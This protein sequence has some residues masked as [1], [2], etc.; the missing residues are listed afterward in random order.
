M[1]PS[2][3]RT[4]CNS[5]AYSSLLLSLI[6]CSSKAKRPRR[7][8][9]VVASSA[10]DAGALDATDDAWPELAK[11]PTIEPVRIVALPARVDVP[12]FTVGGPVIAGGI[13]VAS[14]SQF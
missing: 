13:A 11:L 5:I 9:A 1:L 8:D 2:R 10:K 4:I 12:R 14:S 3:S 7:D 6:A